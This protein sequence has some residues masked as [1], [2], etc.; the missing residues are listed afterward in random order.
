MITNFDT[1][2]PIFYKLGNFWI[3]VRNKYYLSNN[4]N[5]DGQ[6]LM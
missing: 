1:N 5:C 6:N 3:P 2:C 4:L